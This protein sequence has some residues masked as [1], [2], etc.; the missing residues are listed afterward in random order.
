VDSSPESR[1]YLE[2]PVPWDEVIGHVI[3]GG[4]ISHMFALALSSRSTD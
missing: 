2:L 3:I 1:F 4:I